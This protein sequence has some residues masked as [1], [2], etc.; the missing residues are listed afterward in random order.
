MGGG[1]GGGGGGEWTELVCISLPLYVQWSAEEG[2]GELGGLL[3]LLLYTD[4]DDH[5]M[6]E[7]CNHNTFLCQTDTGRGRSDDIRL[8]E[9]T[10]THTT[11]NVTLL[12][13]PRLQCSLCF[14]CN[15]KKT[16]LSIRATSDCLNVYW[17]RSKKCV[18]SKKTPRKIIVIST[19]AKSISDCLWPPAQ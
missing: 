12:W 18:R 14:R 10:H 17:D 16:C 15:E 2:R 7:R 6:S 5:L 19:H 9:H 13:F 11:C 4:G 1:R 8:L 3:L